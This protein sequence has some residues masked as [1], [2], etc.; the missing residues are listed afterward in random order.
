MK[1]TIPDDSIPDV[2]SGSG[3]WASSVYTLYRAGILNGSDEK[4][5]FFPDTNISRAAV[6]AICVRMIQS[7]K[8]V[9][10]PAKLNG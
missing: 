7:D 4:G 6:A 10:A 5:S 9:D 1:N 2:K 8:R 3:Y